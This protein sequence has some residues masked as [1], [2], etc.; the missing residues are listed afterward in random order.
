VLNLSADVGDA[1]KQGQIIGQ[2]DDNLLRTALNQAN[3]ELA[4]LRSE[5]A[6]AQNQVSNARALSGKDHSYSKRRLTQ[7]GSKD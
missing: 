6:R 4:S 1:V 5:V 3:A 7:R 2:L